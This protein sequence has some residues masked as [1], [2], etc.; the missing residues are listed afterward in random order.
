MFAALPLTKIVHAGMIVLAL[1][2]SLPEVVCCCDVSWGPGGLLGGKA[3]CQDACAAGQTCCQQH[4][5]H[6]SQSKFGCQASDCDCTFSIVS[7]APIT[8]TQSV[9]F[10]QLEVV[11]A[12]PLPGC[13]SGAPELLTQARPAVDDAGP[14]LTPVRRCAFLQTWLI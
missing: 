13:P 12:I 7:P 11:D 5:S 1:L 3:L 10:D 14:P 4:S 8:V 9:E 6:E 2:A